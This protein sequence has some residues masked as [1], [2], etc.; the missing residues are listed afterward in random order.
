MRRWRGGAPALP[1]ASACV[2]GVGSLL[3]VCIE[4]QKKNSG[5]TAAL[6]MY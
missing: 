4:K 1:P 6:A 2:V 5:A 3:N